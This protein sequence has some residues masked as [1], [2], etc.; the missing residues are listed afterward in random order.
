MKM[1]FNC[2]KF[3]ET[4]LVYSDTFKKMYKNEHILP[5]PG[6][7][8]FF[9][10]YWNCICLV[11]SFFENFLQIWAHTSSEK[12]FLTSSIRTNLIE[13]QIFPAWLLHRCNLTI[14]GDFHYNHFLHYT[15]NSMMA[16]T[17][18]YFDLNCIPCT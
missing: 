15:M 10:F 7:S 8:C 6:P 17:M 12:P 16:E 2:L 18:T 11:N 9:C 3:A 14:I 4:V 13:V 5:D 1:V